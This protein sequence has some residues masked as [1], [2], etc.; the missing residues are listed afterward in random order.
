MTDPMTVLALT[1]S[2]S[3]RYFRELLAGLTREV[4]GAGGHLVIVETLEAG[5]NR[6]EVGVR[7]ISL[8]RSLGPRWAGSFR[9]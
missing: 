6:D 3:G 4:V 1:P 9:S 5:A 8:L 2:M 7:A